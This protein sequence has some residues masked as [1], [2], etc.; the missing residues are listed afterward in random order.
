MPTNACA[1]VARSC[2]D[3]PVAIEEATGS[4]RPEDGPPIAPRVPTFSPGVAALR[5]A[6][7]G[8][9]QLL[10]ATLEGQAPALECVS[11]TETL[12]NA[13]LQPGIPPP[14]DVVLIEHSDKTAV[15]VADVRARNLE[16][17]IVLLVE[18]ADELAASKHSAPPSTTTSR[19][20][21]TGRRGCSCV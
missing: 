6:Y 1:R 15:A 19:R 5:V 14:F 20:R 16:V 13:D 21:Q 18:A 9:L 4:G 17:A 11:L 3:L 7:T 2:P 8:D 10:Q 12:K